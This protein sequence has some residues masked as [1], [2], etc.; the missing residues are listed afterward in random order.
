M[1]KTPIKKVSAT[2]ADKSVK[3]VAKSKSSSKKKDEN[4]SSV[5]EKDTSA[6]VLKSD[7]L[8]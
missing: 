6:K 3:T 5:K 2:K 7:E 1:P 8:L 4:V